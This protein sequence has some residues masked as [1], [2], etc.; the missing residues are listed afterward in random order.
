MAGGA[1]P[2]ED[3]DGLISGINVTPLVDITLVLLV[4]M[5]VTA[6]IIVARAI[7]VQSPKA[8]T[9]EQVATTIS[10]T[11]RPEN[12]QSALYL[13]GRPIVDR[14]TAAV[15]IRRAV[16]ANPELQVVITADK[17]VPHGDV[18]GLVDLVRLEGVKRFAMTVDELQDR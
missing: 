5:M 16:V 6:R 13:N 3:D 7:P 8:A 12:G 17:V 4:I 14:A 1:S 10:L 11:L 9:G 18:I 15:E 2:Y